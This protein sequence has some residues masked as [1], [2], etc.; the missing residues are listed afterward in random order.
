MSLPDLMSTPNPQLLVAAAQQTLG[1][2]KKRGPPRAI[3]L[4][5][6]GA[7]LAVSRGLKPAVLYDWNSSGVAALQTYLKELQGMGFLPAG[8][9]ILEIGESNLIVSPEHVRQRLERVLLGAVAVVDVSSSRHHP[10][11][12]P[13]DQ[14]PDLK[15][16]I[17]EILTHFRGLQKDVSQGVSH[18]KLRPS[19]WN[20][21]TVFGLLLG[22]PVSYTFH[23][24][25]GGGNCLAMTPLRVFTAQVS[26]QPGQ[27]PVLLYSFSVPESLFPAL[28]DFV[29][30]W[31]EDLRTGLKTQSV[32]AD[33]SI[34]SEVV[35]L[36]AVAL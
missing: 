28:R 36:P 7:V 17:A 12:C 18:S 16:L 2:G 24:S 21:C 4:R 25:H 3:C 32:F 33:L 6:A 15:S 27:L 30:V 23:P 8:L 5:I 34:S 10:S 9:H 14:L 35:T 19:D 20:L 1:T 26:W 29:Q 11:I 31:E 22:Y 13:L